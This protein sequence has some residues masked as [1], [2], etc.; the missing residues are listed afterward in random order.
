MESIYVSVRLI[1]VET[2]AIKTTAEDYVTEVSLPKLIKLAEKIG[3]SLTS[4]S[5]L[6]NNSGNVN[7]ASSG[8][9][10]E[11]FTVNGV[12]FEMVKVDGGSFM[13][14]SREGDSDE[15]PVHSERVGDF[16]IGKT[17]VTQQLWVA[18]MG[19]NPS[20]LR[21]ENLPVENVSWFDCQE[22]VERL[23]RMTGR[24]F[25]LPTETEWEYAARGG[26]RSRGYKYSGSNDLYRVAWYT[27]NSES[28]T[29]P[30]GS[31][32]DNELGLYDMSGNVWEWVSD[33]YSKSY[34]QSRNGSVRV[35]RGGG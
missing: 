16:Y 6:V 30:V 12:T 14:G 20:D 27:E 24:I 23:S 35:N 7:N 8:G 13:M 28:R 15:Q 32:L 4:D 25:R 29:H 21:G 3:T 33:N 31:K 34:L 17:E 11:R 9:T 22:F 10:V 1:E 18:I 26:N 2:G 19:N 5:N